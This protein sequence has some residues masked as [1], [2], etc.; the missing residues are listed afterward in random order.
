MFCGKTF[1]PNLWQ[2]QSSRNWLVAIFYKFCHRCH[3]Q[4][5]IRRLDS[6]AKHPRLMTTKLTFWPVHFWTDGSLPLT[7]QHG[8][9]PSCLCRCWTFSTQNQRRLPWNKNLVQFANCRSPSLLFTQQWTVSG[10]QRNALSFS[11][12]CNGHL[13]ASKNLLLWLAESGLHQLDSLYGAWPIFRCRWPTSF[14]TGPTVKASILV[15]VNR[16]VNIVPTPWITSRWWTDHARLPSSLIRTCLQQ[17]DRT[18]DTPCPPRDSPRSGSH[19][20][21]SDTPKYSRDCKQNRKRSKK[22]V[23]AVFCRFCTIDLGL[24]RGGDVFRQH[25]FG[26]WTLSLAFAVSLKV[27]E[28]GGGEGVQCTFVLVRHRAQFYNDKWNV[29]M[30]FTQTQLTIDHIDSK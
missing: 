6:K 24:R 18:P 3:P 10:P 26:Y 7:L 15:C 11:N 1:S 2:R 28:K 30:T 20:D 14:T 5:K 13:H 22:Q 4:A 21:G 8:R 19:L 9:H 16:F 23:F 29:E 27:G 12:E 25:L 17:R